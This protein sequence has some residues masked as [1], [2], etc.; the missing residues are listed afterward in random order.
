METHL[1]RFVDEHRTNRRFH[2]ASGAHLTRAI[3]VQENWL[4]NVV[5]TSRGGVSCNMSI[6]ARKACED[7]SDCVEFRPSATTPGKR[8]AAAPHLLNS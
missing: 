1:S 2:V 3:S 8:K 5:V 4:G 6:K 7:N